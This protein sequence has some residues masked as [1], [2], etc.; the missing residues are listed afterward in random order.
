MYGFIPI[1]NFMI[2]KQ[3]QLQSKWFI[4]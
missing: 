4:I 3:S 1:P 2:C